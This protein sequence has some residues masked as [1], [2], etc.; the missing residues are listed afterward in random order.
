MMVRLVRIKTILM[1][2]DYYVSIWCRMDVVERWEW[3]FV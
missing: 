3:C 2:C 1:I